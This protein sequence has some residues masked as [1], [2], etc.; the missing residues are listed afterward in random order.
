MKLE[1]FTPIKGF[2]ETH[3]INKD[4]QEVYSFI[5]KRLL[6][7]SIIDGYISY[8]LKT[9]EGQVVIKKLH[10]LM[11][12]T[13][14]PDKTNFKCF[15]ED[16]RKVNL[17]KLVINHIDGNKQNN[18]LE[19]LEWC[20]RAYNNSE[21]YRLGLRKVSQKTI[22]QFKRDCLTSKNIKQAIENLKKSKEKAIQKA[23]E[24]NSF[25]VKLIKDDMEYTF[26]SC[27]D[28]SEFLNVA[29]SSVCRALKRK[30]NHVK[31]YKIEKL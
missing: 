20:T 9:K 12:E 11:M 24:V 6:K 25:K 4:T 5:K 28:A 1:K 3:L 19:N 14:N 29:H 17:D 13:F 15:K 18:R 23:K 30:N 31:G 8:S 16:R 2:E 22:E 7:G 10:R 21:A 26:D 27:N